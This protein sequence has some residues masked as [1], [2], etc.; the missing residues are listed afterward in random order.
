VIQEPKLDGNGSL[1]NPVE[2]VATPETEHIDRDSENRSD[3][4]A[5][6]ATVAVT[7][8][9]GLSTVIPPWSKAICARFTVFKE[10][11]IASAM[12]RWVIPLSRSNTIWM[13]WRCA[14]GIFQP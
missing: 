1:A 3:V 9:I 6:V 12:A 7:P 13:R 14:A 10:S 11:P 5:T 8:A 2:R 4:V